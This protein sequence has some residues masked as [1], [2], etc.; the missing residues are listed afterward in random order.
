MREEQ[1]LKERR[2]RRVVRRAL[3]VVL[4]ERD[5]ARLSNDEDLDVNRVRSRKAVRD[6]LLRGAESLLSE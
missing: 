3:A 6:F 1:K 2:Q 5:S 4:A